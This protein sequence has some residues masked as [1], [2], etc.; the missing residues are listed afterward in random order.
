VLPPAPSEPVTDGGLWLSFTGL[1]HLLVGVVTWVV[2]AVGA[3]A[4]PCVS[5]SSILHRVLQLEKNSLNRNR[6]CAS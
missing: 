2:G 1:P 6:G 5:F 4:S 3:V